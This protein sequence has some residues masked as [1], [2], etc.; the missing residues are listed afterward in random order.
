MRYIQRLAERPLLLD[1]VFAV[2]VTIGVIAGSFPAGREQ[3]DMHPLD[4]LAWAIL[5]TAG[6]S[7]SLRRRLPWL[8][9]ATA[10]TLT[11]TYIYLRYPYGPI[12]LYSMIAVYSAAA[13]R[14][15]AYAL[16]VGALII[17]AHLPWSWLETEPD[18]LAFSLFTGAVWLVSPIAVGIAVRSRRVADRRAHFEERRRHISE[19]RLRLAQEVHDTVGHSL[20]IISANAGAAL[21]VLARTTP[22]PQL[23]ESLRAIRSASGSALDELR[24][25]L[26]ARPSKGL[27]CLPAL[28]DATNVNGLRV[29]LSTMGSPRPVDDTIDLAAYRIVQES[30]A[31]V[32]RHAQAHHAT[33]TVTFAPDSL[34]VHVLDDGIGGIPGPGGTG[35]H[36]MRT[37]TTKLSGD[38]SAGPTPT[39]GFAVH[40]TL[41]YTP[42]VAPGT[43]AARRH[44]TTPAVAQ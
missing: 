33:V 12:F 19:E 42:D 36:S 3:P 5:A 30:L 35:L 23:E 29:S 18:G 25:V 34:T 39:G 6:L 4:G 11:M 27:A 9:V 15:T 28:I 17:G 38:F 14:S 31:N 1:T 32:V 10:F 7:L 22:H 13:W 8:A 43:T 44:A 20:A 41:P 26:A 37:R 2:V 21:H 40:A 24:A 16:T